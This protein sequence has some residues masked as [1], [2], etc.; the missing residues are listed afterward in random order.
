MDAID[1]F[2]EA[3]GITQA[4]ARDDREIFLPGFFASGQNGTDARGVDRD[5]FLGKYVLARL[6]CGYQ[7]LR[8]EVRR[9]CQQDHVDTAVYYLFVSIETDETAVFRDI[10]F[11]G[12]FFI[13]IEHTQA[14]LQPVLKCIPHGHQLDILVGGQCLGR[15]PCPPSATSDEANPQQVTARNVDG[16]G[17]SSMSGYC[18]GHNRCG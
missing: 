1:R 9:L 7:M 13:F 10:Y 16:L 11:I 3:V 18:S 6:D 2:L 14:A 15:C 17:Q 8:S 12:D 5:W 4:E